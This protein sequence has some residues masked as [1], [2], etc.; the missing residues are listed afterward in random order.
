MSNFKTTKLLFDGDMLLFVACLGAEK[1]THWYGDFYTMHC[2][3]GEAKNAFDEHVASLTE[4]VLDHWNIDGKYEIY[5]C[6]TSTD[7]NFRKSIDENYKANREGKRRPMCYIPMREWI[8]DNYNTIEIPMLEADDCVGIHA[9]KNAIAI[10]GDKD[11]RSIPVRFYDFMRNEFYDTTKEEADYFHLYQTLV[12]DTAD[13]Y[14]G[15]P[16][17]GDTRAKRILDEEATFK[18]V[19]AHFEKN[20]SNAEEALKNA[21]LAFILRQGYYNKKTGKVKLWKPS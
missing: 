14:K 1:V 7:G 20:G 5:M 10:S 18:N 6:L 19:V 4:L 15:C 11:F 21:Q 9:D 2:D 12:G 17:V 8:R 3:L 13:N 16:K